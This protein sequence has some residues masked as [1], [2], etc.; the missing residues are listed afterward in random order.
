MLGHVD[1]ICVLI[2]IEE[3]LIT[4]SEKAP[5]EI[6][7]SALV[8]NSVVET[9]ASALV[10]NSVVGLVL[11]LVM[12]INVLQLVGSTF[13]D[14]DGMTCSITVINNNKLWML[15]SSNVAIIRYVIIQWSICYLSPS[16]SVLSLYPQLAESRMM[17]VGMLMLMRH[18]AMYVDRL[19]VYLKVHM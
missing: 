3:L 15:T 11:T 2:V 9:V 13:A 16:H 1:S 17:N 4:T 7:V 12:D 14:D 6:V 19:V 5:V 18:N 10:G 8:D